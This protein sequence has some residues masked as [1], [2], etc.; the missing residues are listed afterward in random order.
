MYNNQGYNNSNHN[1]YPVQSN[2]QKPGYGGGHQGYQNNPPQQGNQGYNN[3]NS[4]TK[5]EPEY[6]DP[7][8]LPPR[9]PHGS[10]GGFDM[11]GEEDLSANDDGLSAEDRFI[12][13]VKEYNER[14][15][16]RTER[17][18]TVNPHNNMM[19]TRTIEIEPFAEE[20]RQEEELTLERI[21]QKRVIKGGNVEYLQKWRAKAKTDKVY[22]GINDSNSWE[23]AWTD[24]IDGNYYKLANEFEKKSSIDKVKVIRTNR[25]RKR[26]SPEDDKFIEEEF[27]SEEIVEMQTV[28]CDLLQENR[29]PLLRTIRRL[30]VFEEPSQDI[31]VVPPVVRTGGKGRPPNPLPVM[32]TR[33]PVSIP[34]PIPE[35]DDVDLK[36]IDNFRSNL[37][38]LFNPN[39]PISGR[40]I[41]ELME[42]KYGRGKTKPE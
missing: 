33:A 28:K 8:D 2:Y 22:Q 3:Y 20:K 39:A 18:D 25:T 41:M 14:L 7:R 23:I 40:A 36:D 19:T 12:R 35:P 29:Q 24:N 4:Q 5:E 13:E 27:K 34:Q 9:N 16:N 15:E 32:V 10:G 26:K 21:L 42:S 30:W 38:A 31:A 37:P 1:G 6:F 11:P 17:I